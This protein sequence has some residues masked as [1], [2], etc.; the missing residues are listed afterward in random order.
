MNEAETTKY[1]ILEIDP[2]S[3]KI[4]KFKE[5]PKSTETESRLA[6]P[7]FYLFQEKAFKL[8]EQFLEERKDGPLSERDAT[9]LILK[10]LYPKIEIGTLMISGRFDVGNLVQYIECNSAFEAK[11]HF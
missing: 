4:T 8:I 6:C 9:G 11:K 7:C 3:R 5:K 10:Y 1:G 2:D